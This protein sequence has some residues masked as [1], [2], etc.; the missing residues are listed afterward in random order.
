MRMTIVNNRSYEKNERGEETRIVFFWKIV[1]IY[2]LS[3]RIY[4]ICVSMCKYEC[5][6]R[7]AKR[8]NF[9]EVADEDDWNVYWTDTSVGIDRVAQMKKWQVRQRRGRTK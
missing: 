6:R 8:L 9:R 3:S 1:C 2:P 7:A 4:Y 5:V